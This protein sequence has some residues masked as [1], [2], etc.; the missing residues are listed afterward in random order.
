MAEIT[1][2]LAVKKQKPRGRPFAKGSVPNPAGRPEEAELFP[3]VYRKLLAQTPE[4]LAQQNVPPPTKELI[5]RKMI[6]R[7]CDGDVAAAKLIQ[8]RVDGKA[9]ESVAHTVEGIPDRIAIEFVEPTP[10]KPHA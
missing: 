5:A 7:A 9:P 10:A 1:S 2:N 3:P 8:E 6:E 4:Q